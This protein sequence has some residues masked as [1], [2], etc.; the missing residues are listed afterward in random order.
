MITKEQPAIKRCILHSKCR[1][2][3]ETQRAMLHSVCT[4]VGVLESLGNKTTI[5]WY[6]CATRRRVSNRRTVRSWPLRV[7]NSYMH[8]G[9]G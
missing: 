7:G 9:A 4:F 5:A 8:P 2:T 3:P 6:V 1:H